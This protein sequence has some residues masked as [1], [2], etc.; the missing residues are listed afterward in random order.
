[1]SFHKGLIEWL[2]VIFSMLIV[3]TI[4][5]SMEQVAAV[6]EAITASSIISVHHMLNS[7]EMEMARAALSKHAAAN[8]GVLSEDYFDDE[9]K[10]PGRITGENLQISLTRLG[11]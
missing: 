6:R 4:T 2:K 8:S 9:I 5:L 1:M 11:S 3:V 7:T 10:Y